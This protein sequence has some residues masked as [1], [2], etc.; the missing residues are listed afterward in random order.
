MNNL[1]LV[2]SFAKFRH[3]LR[4]LEIATD[5]IPYNEFIAYVEKYAT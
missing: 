3:T 4:R 5:K 1:R 2:S